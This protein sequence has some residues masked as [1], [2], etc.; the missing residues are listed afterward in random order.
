M[1]LRWERCRTFFCKVQILRGSRQRPKAIPHAH[2]H[3][4]LIARRP[5]PFTT[6]L[7][8]TLRFLLPTVWLLGF[9]VLMLMLLMN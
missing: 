9:G 1:C 3:N 5:A 6:G 2:R 7:K 8:N 4:F